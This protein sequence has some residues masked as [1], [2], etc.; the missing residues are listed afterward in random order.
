MAY[1]SGSAHQ[2]NQ[3]SS[4]VSILTLGTCMALFAGPVLLVG[5]LGLPATAG[6]VIGLV[7]GGAACA[8]CAFLPPFLVRNRVPRLDET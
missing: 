6:K 8:A 7:L 2:C 1:I 5:W 4:I 3:L